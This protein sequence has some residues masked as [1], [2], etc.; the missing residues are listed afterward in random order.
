MPPIAAL[1]APAACT[2]GWN[3]SAANPPQS[4]I[5]TAR[6]PYRPSVPR[7]ASDAAPRAGVREAAGQSRIPSSA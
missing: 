1:K 2:R 4:A 5:Q 3:I 7:S 6:A